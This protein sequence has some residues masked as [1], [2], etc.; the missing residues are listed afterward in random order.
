ME[1]L[2]GE[3]LWS[4]RQE[5]AAADVQLRGVPVMFVNGRSQLNPQGMDTSN[6]D[7]CLSS[8]L[9]DSED[10]CPRKNKLI[11]ELH[12]AREDYTRLFYYLINI[13]TVLDNALPLLT[14]SA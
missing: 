8:M 13:N 9:R 3:N 14:Y 1:Q 6:M 2:R 12:K 7:V 5:K 10:I 4:L 11:V